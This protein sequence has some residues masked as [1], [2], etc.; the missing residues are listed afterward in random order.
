M[1][2]EHG[3]YLGGAAGYEIDRFDPAF[4]S[5]PEAVVLATSE[6]LHPPSYLLVIEDMEVTIAAITSADSDRVRADVVYLPYPE[7]GAVFSV[8]SCS[9]C[10]SLSSSTSMSTTS[11]ASPRTCCA[12]SSRDDFRG[13]GQRRVR[14]VWSFEHAPGRDMRATPDEIAASFRAPPLHATP[15]RRGER[16]HV[17]IAEQLRRQIQLGMIPPGAALPPERELTRIYHAGRATV[18][19]ALNLL[20]GDGLIRRVRGRGGGTF[21]EDSI[22]T[23][24]NLDV[25]IQRVIADRTRIEEAIAFRALIEPG[26][27]GRSFPPAY[28]RRPRADPRGT[29]APL[30]LGS[31]I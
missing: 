12:A 4:G 31:R 5:P 8:G 6:G 1:I 29:D 22:E 10:G 26:V 17:V 13:R 16:S 21:V 20:H 3:L 9:W 14:G 7:G 24:H 23:E 2:G 15:P 11:R 19:Q 30:R 28:E 25:A 18:Q 27:A